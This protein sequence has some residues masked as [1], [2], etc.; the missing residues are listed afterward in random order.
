MKG[1]KHVRT[2]NGVHGP[3]SNEPGAPYIYYP[4]GS[5][6]PWEYDLGRGF[7]AT[8]YGKGWLVSDGTT[9]NAAAS[10]LDEAKRIADARPINPAVVAFAQLGKIVAALDA[11]HAAQAA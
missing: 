6:L 1:I 5:A 11:N 7:S 9:W 4:P 8:R 10:T 3:A 2:K